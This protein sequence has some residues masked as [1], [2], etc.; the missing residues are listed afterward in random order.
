VTFRYRVVIHNGDAKSAN[1][2]QKF[3]D[4]TAQ[5]ALRGK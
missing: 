2:D 3:K 4:Y 5:V 1:L